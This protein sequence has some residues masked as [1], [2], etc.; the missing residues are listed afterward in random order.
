M[1][2]TAKRKEGK[3]M[4]RIIFLVLLMLFT[5]CLPSY[6]SQLEF[7]SIV[8]GQLGGGVYNAGLALA[9]AANAS[10]DRYMVEALPTSGQVENANLLFDGD[11]EIAVLGTDIH[12]E[13]YYGLS[14]FEGREWKG[15]RS[16][17]PLYTSCVYFAA[18]KNSSI[19]TWEDMKG[20]RIGVGNPGS[21]AYS[22]IK[23]ILAAHGLNEGD[24]SESTISPADLPAA[25]KDGHVD[26]F[27]AFTTPNSP[28]VVELTTVMDVNFIDVRPEM[29]NPYAE[30]NRLPFILGVEPAGTYRGQDVDVAIL[31][32]INY[33]STSESVPEEMIYEFTKAFF[34]NYDMAVDMVVAIGE[35]KVLLPIA[36]PITPYHPGAE[37][38]LKEAGFAYVPYRQ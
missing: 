17:F 30:A 14:R 9:T 31:N 15:L 13:F 24:Y 37:R 28:F 12:M 19:L 34:S 10:Q 1:F 6:G 36:E 33:I 3:M 35:V 20:K 11:T 2:I 18:P 22:L 27:A 7:I 5:V 21:S 8:T 26:V 23:N 29:W 38:Y 32:G 16:M 25:I 4:K